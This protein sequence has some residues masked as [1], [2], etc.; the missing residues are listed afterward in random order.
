MST[1][2]KEHD[3]HSTMSASHPSPDW[4]HQPAHYVIRLMGHLDT[5]WAAWFAGL[6]LSHERDGTTLIQGPIPDQAALHGVLRRV[7]DLGLPLILV[8]QVDPNQ[9]TEAD[10][11]GETDRYRSNTETDR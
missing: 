11:H 3:E 7:R 10:V 1:I 5:R 4:S 2:R 8:M 6:S 9:A